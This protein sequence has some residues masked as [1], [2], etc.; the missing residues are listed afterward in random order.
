MR[1]SELSPFFPVLGAE[2]DGRQTPPPLG[3]FARESLI[4]GDQGIVAGKS[5][6]AVSADGIRALSGQMPGNLKLWDLESGSL[7]REFGE[8]R[9]SSGVVAVAFFH[10]GMAAVSR[11]ILGQ[12]TLG[13][14]PGRTI[15]LGQRTSWIS[16][17]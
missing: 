16:G 4:C 15:D 11:A 10:D 6:V 3:R 7:I 14:R 8:R 5:A 2:T 13:T 17:I 12:G 9:R 1:F